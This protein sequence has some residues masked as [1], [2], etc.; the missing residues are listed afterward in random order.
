MGAALMFVDLPH[1]WSPPEPPPPQRRYPELTIRQQKVLAW[2]IGFNV[3]MLFLAPI[4]GV[5]LFDVIAA[6]LRN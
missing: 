2:I 3:L 1:Y 5:T 6:V 4:A